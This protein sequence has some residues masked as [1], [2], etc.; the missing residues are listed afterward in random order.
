M[1]GSEMRTYTI[2]TFSILIG[3]TASVL[4]QAFHVET[5]SFLNKRANTTAELVRQVRTDQVVMERYMRH[6]RMS[7]GE[8]IDMFSHLHPS[9]LQQS[10]AYTVYN[11]HDDNIIRARVF[12]LKKGTPIFADENGRAVLKRSCGNPFFAPAPKTV[13]NFTPPPQERPHEVPPPPP[14]PVAPPAEVVCPPAPPAPCPVMPA[15]P[16][17]SGPVTSSSY[18]S[19]SKSSLFIL[20]I[21]L[22]INHHGSNNCCT[23]CPPQPVPEPGSMLVMGFGASWIALRR[24]RKT[25]AKV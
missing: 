18:V 17:V 23:T 22:F 13:L 7:G 12:K 6:Y 4:S 21:L 11:I 1:R 5:G 24:R 20:P 9:M 8:I 15:Q 2:K 10:G 16:I 14:A 19:E 25:H 3:L